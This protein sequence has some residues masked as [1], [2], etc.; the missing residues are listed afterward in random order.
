MTNLKFN[1][2]KCNLLRYKSVLSRTYIIT[3]DCARRDPEKI[4][5]VDTGITLKI[6]TNYVASLGSV[7]IIGN[8]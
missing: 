7:L 8:L 5:A 4:S 6:F 3:D 2:A 1:F